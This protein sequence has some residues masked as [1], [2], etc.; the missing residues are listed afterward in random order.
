VQGFPLRSGD[1]GSVFAPHQV[2]HSSGRSVQPG[3]GGSSSGRRRAS[4]AATAAAAA[5]AD[6]WTGDGRAA[7]EASCGSTRS[8]R[9][10]RSSRS[11]S[12][13]GSGSDSDAEDS[14]DYCR[15]GYHR[16][17]PG[18]A[19]KS[20]RY[21]LLT[22]L[23]WGHFSTVWLAWDASHRCHVALKIQKSASHYTDAARDEIVILTTLRDA[24]MAGHGG[25][26]D[27]G[28]GGSGGRGGPAVVAA[29]QRPDI[30]S[31]L[32]HFDHRGPNG[33][34]VC[35]VF[36]VLGKSLLS[37]IKRSAYAG[38][39][40]SAVKAVARQALTALAFVHESCQVI[41]TDIK[42][43]NI[44][45]RMSPSAAAALDRHA[46]I[47]AA[48]PRIV[49][50]V[51][52][53]RGGGGRP[54]GGG[55]SSG[56]S[57]GPAVV[58]ASTAGSA[59]TA[60][61]GGVP[62]SKNQ[63]K[64]QRLKAKKVAAAAA[65]EEAVM[66]AAAAELSGG[67]GAGGSGG[68]NGAGGYIR[69]GGG[70]VGLRSSAARADVGSASTVTGAT[71]SAGVDPR[72]HADAALAEAVAELGASVAGDVTLVDFGN[73]CWIDKH[74]TEDIQTTQYRAPEVILGAGYDPSADVWSL[75]CV[76]FELATGDFL[77]DPHSNDGYGRDEDH[78]AQVLELVGPTRLPP[79]LLRGTYARDLFT[80][81]GQLRRIRRLK[82]WPLSAVLCDKYQMG[83]A[84]AVGFAAFLG[85]MLTVSP[86]ERVT[87]SEAVADPFL[88]GED[89]EE[90]EGDA[91]GG[92]THAHAGGGGGVIGGVAVARDR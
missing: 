80:R 45:F 66:A 50:A 18:D 53:G 25:E 89:G 22:R 62:L 59:T 28:G 27:G 2:H 13:S 90:R 36:P 79:A 23:G 41:H 38:L 48:H 70:V 40:L 20:G 37:A 31:L 43:E 6:G 26:V 17:S 51:G 33:K 60:T 44:L 34:H 3:G 73:A 64:R 52:R 19:L 5:D 24:G 54:G 77:F 4:A 63:R 47:V 11:R 56:G 30:V 82:Y 75:G 9:S 86:G 68:A 42:P 81:S 84:D 55:G 10:N 58:E 49:S 16:A 8:S 83:R 1:G 35:L 29:L 92:D 32:D 91:A 57:G 87:A 14:A 39:P 88:A 78:M 74:F 67:G 7:R 12:V 71:S 76:L 46:A 85:R 15:G 65:R 61:S 72:F 69:N 21:R